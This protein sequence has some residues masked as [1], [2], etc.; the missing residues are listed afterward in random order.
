MA[1]AK[2]PNQNCQTHKRGLKV[3]FELQ[4][5]NIG[6]KF[7]Y[8]LVKCTTCGTV[9]GILDY[10]N[11]GVVLEDHD[12]SLVD[13]IKKQNVNNASIIDELSRQTNAIRQI[14]EKIGLN[15]II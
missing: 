9:I 4:E 1:L 3:N 7:R 6:M 11:I 12:R 8:L 15:D 13:F 14:A 2:C 5:E 10:L